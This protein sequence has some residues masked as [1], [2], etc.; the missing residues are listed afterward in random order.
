MGRRVEKRVWVD[1]EEGGER[2]RGLGLLRL[3][4]PPGLVAVKK[5]CWGF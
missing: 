5:T 2:A 1:G 4:S 3:S